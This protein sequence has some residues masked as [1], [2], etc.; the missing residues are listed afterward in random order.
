[1]LES[2][3]R[4]ICKME[5][6]TDETEN[7]K[8]G[9]REELENLYKDAL[10]NGL[11]RHEVELCTED[12]LSS[13][14]VHKVKIVKKNKVRTEFDWLEWLEEDFTPTSVSYNGVKIK[15]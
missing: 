14:R 11:K 1:M 6:E 8:D 12:V 2:H 7:L 15:G 10:E 13:F 5:N 9:F 4:D 3:E